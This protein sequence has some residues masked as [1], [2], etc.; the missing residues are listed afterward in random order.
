MVAYVKPEFADSWSGI[1]AR[2]YGGRQ[3]VTY[4]AG[5]AAYLKRAVPIVHIADLL[6]RPEA[7]LEGHL[8][9]ARTPFTYLNRLLF[10]WRLKRELKA[11]KRS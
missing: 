6:Y 1:R 11:S 9:V 8:K 7:A 10:K 3:V 2:E 4:C 5:C